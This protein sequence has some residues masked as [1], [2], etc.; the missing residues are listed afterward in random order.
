MKTKSIFIVIMLISVLLVSCAQAEAPDAEMSME[1][2]A[3]K[4]GAVNSYGMSDDWVNLGYMW[5]TIEDRYDVVHT[6]IDMTSAEQITRLD[7]EKEAP[8]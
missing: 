7:A 5:K 1:E 3:A 8:V 6:D 2:G 4:E